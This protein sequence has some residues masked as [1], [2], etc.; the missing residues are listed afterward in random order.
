MRASASS[1]RRRGGKGN[2]SSIQ[3]FISTPVENISYDYY[4]EFLKREDRAILLKDSLKIRGHDQ[5]WQTAEVA[6]FT[7]SS[8][9]GRTI[10]DSNS[11]RAKASRR[12]RTTSIATAAL[13][14]PA[15]W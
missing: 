14:P 6:A 13:V 10:G 4:M 7:L 3:S 5:L 11:R 1:D 8:G 2:W 15:T 12:G 9:V